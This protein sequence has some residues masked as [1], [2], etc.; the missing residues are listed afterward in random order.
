VNL[1]HLCWCCTVGKDTT[2][3]S[4]RTL[5]TSRA[6]NYRRRR[7]GEGCSCRHRNAWSWSGSADSS[8][9][10]QW[11]R[12]TTLEGSGVGVSDKLVTNNWLICAWLLP[13]I[14]WKTYT[15]EC[16]RALFKQCCLLM[17]MSIW[18][19]LQRVEKRLCELILFSFEVRKF[20]LGLYNEQSGVT[21]QCVP[22]MIRNCG[23]AVQKY[24]LSANLQRSWINSCN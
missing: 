17:L 3:I 23:C 9:Q 8:R 5:E 7:L 20:G 24:I 12:C 10:R 14:S 15:S 22:V 19:L 2:Q 1:V 21:R 6:R 16:C 18:K 11:I 13:R 4:R